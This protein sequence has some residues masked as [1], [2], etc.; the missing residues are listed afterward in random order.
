MNHHRRLIDS[1]FNFQLC[2]LVSLQRYT[3]S[4]SNLQRASLV[5]KSRQKPQERMRTLTNVSYFVEFITL[6]FHSYVTLGI[7]P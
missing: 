4:L 3:K 6:I 1:Y 7:L 2:K 5:E